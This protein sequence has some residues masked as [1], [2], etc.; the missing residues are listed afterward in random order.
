MVLL[1]IQG[2]A[3]D[4]ELSSNQVNI[5]LFPL[6]ISYQGK[7]GEK[8]SLNLAAGLGLA[9]ESSSNSFSDETDFNFYALPIVYASFRNYYKRK[10]TRKDNLKNNSGNYVAL[11]GSFQFEPTHNPSTLLAQT[12][13]LQV[14][15]VFTIGPV[16]GFE[17]NYASG[18]HLGL[19]IGPG[20]I[21][22]EYVDTEFSIIGEFEFGFVLFSK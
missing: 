3:Q 13:A 21:G 11:Y 19:S 20:V 4:V 9:A 5:N 10:F 6:T 14:T 1:S 22:G 17:R 18:I 8:Q 12:R 2:V 7:I 15:N 16:W